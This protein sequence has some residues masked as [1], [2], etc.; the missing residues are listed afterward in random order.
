MVIKVEEQ[1]GRE[2]GAALIVDDDFLAFAHA[3]RLNVLLHFGGKVFSASEREHIDDDRAENMFSR[4]QLGWC[5]VEYQHIGIL[6]IFSSQATLTRLPLIPSA[7]I[8]GCDI[9]RQPPKKAG[10]NKL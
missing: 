7:A 4:V 6:N 9:S 2:V 5:G 1:A 3:P 8:A 10:S